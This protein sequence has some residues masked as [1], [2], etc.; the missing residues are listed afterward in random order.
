MLENVKYLYYFKLIQDFK[1]IL[2]NYIVMRSNNNQTIRKIYE[3]R[4]L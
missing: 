4:N 1:I 2:N 3:L